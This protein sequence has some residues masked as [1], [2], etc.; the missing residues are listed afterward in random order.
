[1]TELTIKIEGELT[2]KEFGNLV[3][4][5][6]LKGITE[7]NPKITSVEKV[8]GIYP[9]YEQVVFK[10]SV[11]SAT[12]DSMKGEYNS[13]MTGLNKLLEVIADVDF[14]RTEQEL[15]KEIIKPIKIF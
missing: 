7:Y 12:Y 3:D 13:N 9:K 8:E 5:L 11:D 14:R 2:D 10:M 4:V 15:R 6:S 1:M